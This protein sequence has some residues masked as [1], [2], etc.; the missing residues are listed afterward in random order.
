M[1]QNLFLLVRATPINTLKTTLGT[2]FGI[3]P[4]G[5]GNVFY[6]LNGNVMSN[7]RNENKNDYLK[8]IFEVYFLT[9]LSH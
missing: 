4:Q 6:E 1:Q 7:L 2:K 9:A 5:V 8:V 3:I